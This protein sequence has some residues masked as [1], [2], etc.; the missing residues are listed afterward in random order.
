MA[1][2][3]NKCQINLVANGIKITFQNP[4]NP[5][6]PDETIN[7]VTILGFSGV[8]NQK[9]VTAQDEEW[10]YPYV[11]MT[12][13]MVT[14]QDNKSYIIELQNVTNKPLWSTGTPAG[15]AQAIA[16]LNAWL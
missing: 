14:L 4:P 6:Q 13:V 3:I 2:N 10:I 5:F 7:R 11:A 1:S 8:F 15:L 9:P 16:D 12:Q